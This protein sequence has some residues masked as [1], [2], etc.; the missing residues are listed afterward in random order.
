MSVLSIVIVSFNARADLQACLLSLKKGPPALEHEL[1]RFLRESPIRLRS[2]SDTI[3]APRIDVTYS[4]MFTGVQVSK[5]AQ[6][7]VNVL[8]DRISRGET[9]L[10]LAVGAEFLGSAMKRLTK[11]LG[12][13]DW[14]EDIDHRAIEGAPDDRGVMRGKAA[15]RAYAQDWFDTFDDLVTEAV[16]LVDAGEDKVVAVLGS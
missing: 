11:G 15:L 13:D 2:L 8:A 5:D 16:E 10:G 14:A 1:N 3:A 12:F 9:E 7:V 6:Q 4:P